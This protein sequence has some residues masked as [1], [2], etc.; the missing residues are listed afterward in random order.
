LVIA[1]VKPFTIISLISSVLGGGDLLL[2]GGDR[3][4]LKRG[5]KF[6]S[7]LGERDG[8]GEDD[9]DESLL[10]DEYDLR[11]RL[12]GERDL[13]LSEELEPGDRERPLG[14]CEPCFVFVDPANSNFTN[15]QRHEQ[16]TSVS[17][18]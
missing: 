17:Y 7:L 16:V 15:N 10:D 5:D 2:R 3:F 13:S 8:D 6:L 18:C 1:F 12:G 11:L 14:M 9:N 4:F